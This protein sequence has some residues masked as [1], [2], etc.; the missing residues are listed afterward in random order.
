[1]KI[2]LHIGLPVVAY[3]A[4]T[5]LWG[6]NPPNYEYYPRHKLSICGAPE[7]NPSRRC[8]VVQATSQGDAETQWTLVPP[9]TADDKP[10]S[11]PVEGL[12]KARVQTEDLERRVC[13]NGPTDRDNIRALLLQVVLQDAS[14]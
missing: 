9:T 7:E 12:D 14:L 1:M 13:I 6:R 11:L 2:S 10:R 4:E 3:T 5:G 8:R